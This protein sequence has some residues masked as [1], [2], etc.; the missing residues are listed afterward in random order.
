MTEPSPA[1]RQSPRAAVSQA[2]TSDS[3]FDD[4]KLL[5]SEKG[6]G[7]SEESAME[8]G[9]DQQ[10]PVFQSFPG[11]TGDPAGPTA[12]VVQQV[13]SAFAQATA[14]EEMPTMSQNAPGMVAVVVSNQ[15][16]VDLSQVSS[17]AVTVLDIQDPGTETL[18]MANPY[19]VGMAAASTGAEVPVPPRHLVLTQT[20]TTTDSAATCTSGLEGTSQAASQVVQEKKGGSSDGDL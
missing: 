6:S 20:P 10:Q 3:D 15:P 14:A 7:P 9:E 17:A 19:I 4:N 18:D 12:Q 16:E 5:K 11:G 1:G 8:D 13:P 2:G